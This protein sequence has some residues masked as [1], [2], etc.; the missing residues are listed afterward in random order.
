VCSWWATHLAISTQHPCHVGADP[1]PW[2]ADADVVLVLD[3]L[4]PWWPDRHPLNAAAK[5][6][7]MGP[8]PIFSR[9]PVRNFRSDIAI[10]G[11]SAATIPALIAAMAK[12][13]RDERAIVARRMRLAEAAETQ[14]AR[15]RQEATADV[16][17]GMTKAF[18]SQ[19]LSEVLDGMTSSVFSELGTML[20]SLKRT[21]HKSW[22]QEPHSGGLGWSFPAALGAQLA[23]PDRVCVATMGDGSYMFAN[24]TVCHQIAEALN[25]PVLILVLNN[26]EWGAVRASVAGLYPGAHAV[27]ANEMPLT[28]LKPSP[29][30]TL[31][32]SAS[33]AWARRVIAA[34]DLP[35]MLQQ[36]LK[37][38][39][40]EKRQALLDIKILP[41]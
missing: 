18:V 41:E 2:L 30:F 12:C 29:D 3:C 38:V 1:G 36:A 32:A 40:W 35:K 9:F 4:A 28:A 5:V 27:K 16:G 39:R 10:A 23:E 8:D 37:V 19:C 13:A 15:L 21:D 31:T 22:F 6:I 11:E 24:P 17:R 26:E 20:G 33:R 14:R 25:L 34:S 7:N